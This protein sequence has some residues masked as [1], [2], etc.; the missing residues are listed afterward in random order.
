MSTSPA[1][2]AEP[3]ENRPVPTVLL[4]EASPL[5]RMAVAAYLRQ[6]GYRVIETD[7][8]WEARSVL[9]AG[10]APEVAFIDLDADGELDGFGLARWIRA[11]RPGIRVLLTSGVRR[12]AETAGDLC[13]QGPHLAKPYDH[14]ELER[15][16]RRLLAG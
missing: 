5:A 10:G 12:T 9:Q 8:P 16:I 6:C 2:T 4:V 14:R 1:R 7:G 15:Q 11:Q 3:P 13:E